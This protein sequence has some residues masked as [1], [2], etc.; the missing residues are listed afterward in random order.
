MLLL[1][2]RSIKY[3]KI[4]SLSCL[5]SVY[6]QL[7]Y[8]FSRL[9]LI[10]RLC[11]LPAHLRECPHFRI[12]TS[13]FDRPLQ[14]WQQLTWTLL[15]SKYIRRYFPG[16]LN[17]SATAPTCSTNTFI[18]PSK[19]SPSLLLAYDGSLPLTALLVLFVGTGT[20]C[21]K[22]LGRTGTED[23]AYEALKTRN[24]SLDPMED[25]IPKITEPVDPLVSSFNKSRIE[26]QAQANLQ[27]MEARLEWL[28]RIIMNIAPGNAIFFR[29][30][31]NLHLNVNLNF[32][33][34]T[35]YFL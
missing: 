30:C 29:S 33:C 2:L 34:P 13:K 12:H 23:V 8:K 27:K 31:F 25:E 4:D 3:S 22:M 26:V 17:Y 18:K 11:N 14:A 10:T 16:K 7:R 32:R 35:A 20:L 9:H 21:C 5:S 28:E 24:G 15:K 6:R 19:P 1:I